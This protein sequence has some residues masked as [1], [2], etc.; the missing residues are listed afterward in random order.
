MHLLYCI[1]AALVVLSIG[2]VI[3]ALTSKTEDPEDGK[4][5]APVI[6]IDEDITN[7]IRYSFRDRKEAN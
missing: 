2:V 6:D 7:D 5:E 4:H 3:L 1:I